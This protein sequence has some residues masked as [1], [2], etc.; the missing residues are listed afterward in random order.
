[1]PP[2]LYIQS[3]YSTF[4]I[5]NKLTLERA[6]INLTF[7]PINELKNI[8]NYGFLLFQVHFTTSLNYIL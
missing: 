1:M 8:I 2:I 6:N 4:F 7:I 5:R 3:N